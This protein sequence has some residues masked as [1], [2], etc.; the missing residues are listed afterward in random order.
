MWHSFKFKLSEEKDHSQQLSSKRAAP[1]R[2]AT[3]NV[4]EVRVVCPGCG[5]SFKRLSAHRPFCKRTST[6]SQQKEEK[7]A[8]V[9]ALPAPSVSEHLAPVPCHAQPVSA[10]LKS[11]LDMSAVDWN[12][13]NAAVGSF[14]VDKFGEPNQWLGVGCD[15]DA[16][17]D[18]FSESVYI[19]LSDH[20]KNMQKPAVRRRHKRPVMSSIDQAKRELKQLRAELKAAVGG[21]KSVYGQARDKFFQMLELISE[22]RQREEVDSDGKF[23]IAES[24]RF[25][26]NPFEYVKRMFGE[27]QKAPTF[28]KSECETFFTKTYADPDRESRA[29]STP[30]CLPT[31]PAI[32]HPFR[33]T[34]W[35]VDDLDFVLKKKR[36]GSAVG[37][38]DGIGYDVFKRCPATW[39][40]LLRL[41]NKA[42]L[43][44]HLPG[45]VPKFGVVRLL[46]KGGDKDVESNPASF[47]PICLSSC[48]WKIFSSL[49]LRDL[50]G[51]AL[52][53]NIINQSIQKGFLDCPGCWEHAFSVSLACEVARIRHLKL[54]GVLV[55]IANAFGSAKHSFMLYVLRRYGY[56]DWLQQLVADWYSGLF[57][58]VKTETF[59]SDPVPFRVGVWQGDPFSVGIFLLCMNP[60]FERLAVAEKE[61]GWGF[62]MS[63]SP[64]L[65]RAG[66]HSSLFTTGFADDCALFCSDTAT[67]QAALDMVVEFMDWSTFKLKVPKCVSFF[68]RPAPASTRM[69]L[70]DPKLTIAGESVRACSGSEPLCLTGS[71]SPLRF[72]GRYLFLSRASLVNYFSLAHRDLI[73]RIHDLPIRGPQKA[74][75]YSIAV[76]WVF[77]WPMSLYDICST[78]LEQ[79][80]RMARVY[81][82]EWCGLAKCGTGDILFLPPHMGGLGV[83]S[84]VSFHQRQRA[85]FWFHI[86]HSKDPVI[87]QRHLIA[88][89]LGICV[90]RP[91][92]LG[93]APG[94]DKPRHRAGVQRSAA[95]SDQPDPVRAAMAALQK[96]QDDE[97]LSR[98]QAKAWQGAVFRTEIE[99]DRSWVR[100][101]LSLPPRLLKFGLNFLVNT[102]PSGHNL[103]RWGVTQDESC[104]LCGGTQSIC[105]VLS[106]CRASLDRFKWRHDGILRRVADFLLQ[107]L[108]PNVSLY[109]DLPGHA[110]CYDKLP[111]VLRLDSLLRPDIVLINAAA[112]SCM[113][114][115]LSVPDDENI[116]KR[117]TQKTDK[118]MNGLCQ[119]LVAQRRN[120]TCDVFAFE[121]STR[122]FVSGS[123]KGALMAVSRRWKQL[124]WVAPANF[125]SQVNKLIDSCSMDALRA[126]YIIWLNRF[127]RDSFI[128][129]DRLVD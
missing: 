41:F 62:R 28:S 42:K 46:F 77:G 9:V 65:A 103:K 114:L 12:V 78:S 34:E 47:R 96:Q 125:V 50:L 94:F 88:K 119:S 58:V 18:R 80:D 57:A 105:H 110:N 106:Y 23:Q 129:P 68:L 122:G 102:L 44:H 6:A 21:D 86:E 118:Y 59:V 54:V 108:P 83:T 123:L 89:E 128:H 4:P 67:A 2:S 27:S 95:Q 60:L 111:D 66:A 120:W 52:D 3:R 84:M 45:R 124:D 79:M 85:S 48:M 69:E 33:V 117:H 81:L 17:A 87:H 56:P 115:E 37:P 29:F 75:A 72:L 40:Y 22:L 112:K 73:K 98:L 61:K 26:N 104:P 121:I 43:C 92:L 24:V 5:K 82:R 31:V 19:F 15:F 109:V 20:V 55:D 53:N 90:W 30:S 49:L 38:I 97:R 10:D 127:T 14:L 99:A 76:K 70:A 116:V 101:A 13:V 16:E 63:G 64:D 51:F 74:R 36:S 93:P 91:F 107:Y 25:D 113:F 35:T 8:A 39:P 1:Y 71:D 126:S 100:N 7:A 11:R 32:Q